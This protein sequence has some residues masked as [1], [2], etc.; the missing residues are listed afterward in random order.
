MTEGRVSLAILGLVALIA[1]TGLVTLFSGRPTGN[2][3]TE[4]M[5]GGYGSDKLY[6]NWPYAEQRI[7]GSL[8]KG[9][10]QTVEGQNVAEVGGASSIQRTPSYYTTCAQGERSVDVEEMLAMEER[11]STCSFNAGINRWC[12][13]VVGLNPYG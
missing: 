10:E 5:Y 7:H 9:V 2:V 4:E 11:G 8:V 13:S 6:G 3:V 12:C 1:V